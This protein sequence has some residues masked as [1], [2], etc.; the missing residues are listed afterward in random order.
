[1]NK[2]FSF[3][4]LNSPSWVTKCFPYIDPFTKPV[5]P[6]IGNIA[7]GDFEA[8]IHAVRSF[9][10]SVQYY[11]ILDFATGPGTQCSCRTCGRIIM[12]I[13]LRTISDILSDAS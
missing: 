12:Y 2:S 6:F 11:V 7:K 8:A 13:P 1:M 4:A 9:L 10:T 5:E 3:L